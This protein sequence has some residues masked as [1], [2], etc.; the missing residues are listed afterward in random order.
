LDRVLPPLSDS[1]RRQS[2]YTSNLPPL[3]VLIVDD[4]PIARLVLRQELVL[5]KEVEVVGEADSGGTA[6]LLISNLA[7]DLVLLDIQMPDMGGFEV[8]SHL[9]SGPLPV[10][11][12]VTA[13]DQH[14]I[15][16]FDAGAVDYLLKP[17]SQP[18]LVQAVERAARLRRNPQAVAENIAH[19]Q[20]IIPAG[21]PP[22]TRIQKIVG[23]AGEEYFLLNPD[24]VLAFQA[25]GDL[26]WILTAK[27]RYQATQ[28]LKT[29][30][31]RLGPGSFRRVH[32]NALVNINQIRKMSMLTSQRWLIT[33]SNGQEFVV[34]K[35]QA[36]HVR[37]VL[38]W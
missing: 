5:L 8:L 13:F 37:D 18:R 19:L 21:T 36:R 27:Q 12:M 33:L 15:R 30:E 7:P 31:D 38:H 26:V 35:R 1:A 2:L 23:K 29:I 14:A 4:E 10:I 24:E 17:V 32:R 22:I 3:R 6:L 28:S 11:V 25:S 9:G 34:S 16:A 20:R